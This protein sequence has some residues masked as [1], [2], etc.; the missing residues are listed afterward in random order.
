MIGQLCTHA[1]WP[2][3][4]DTYISIF[5]HVI[6]SEKGH[7]LHNI[8]IA[9]GY[10]ERWALDESQKMCQGCCR[11]RCRS[12]CH[13]HTEAVFVPTQRCDVLN[14]QIPDSWVLG[15]ELW[16]ILKT[17]NII[18]LTYVI[19]VATFFDTCYL[20]TTTVILCV[21]YYLFNY[22]LSYTAFEVDIWEL[23]NLMMH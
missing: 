8:C 17:K 4:P 11:C 6:S 13:P 7:Q 19:N 12:F 2:K 20:N 14:E 22:C 5:M 1:C 16:L 3:S 23:K 18:L 21:Y 9:E 15:Q 10:T